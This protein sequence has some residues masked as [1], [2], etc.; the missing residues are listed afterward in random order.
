MRRLGKTETR[1]VAPE[2]PVGDAPCTTVRESTAPPIA[3]RG[4]LTKA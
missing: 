1:R 4:A 3:R 2:K